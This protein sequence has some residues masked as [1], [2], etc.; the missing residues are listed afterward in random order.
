MR[1]DITNT[2]KHL[3]IDNINQAYSTGN[4]WGSGAD[5]VVKEIISPVDGQKIA[6]VKIATPDQYNLAVEQAAESF[7]SW[8]AVP[9]PKRGEII[10]QIGEAL[11]E[12]K[13]HRGKLV[14]Y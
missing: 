8:R 2:L 3:H 13:E 14:S 6:S 5:N 4:T 9:A 7:K 12:N 11:R 10:R 1:V